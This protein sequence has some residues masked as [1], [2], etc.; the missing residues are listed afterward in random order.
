MSLL[1]LSTPRS[2]WREGFLSQGSVPLNLAEPKE[3]AVSPTLTSYLLSLHPPPQEN[4]EVFRFHLISV[5]AG[6][7]SLFFHESAAAWPQTVMPMVSLSPPAGGSCDLQVNGTVHLRL[8]KCKA[9]MS[10]SHLPGIVQL[11]YRS[12]V[13][14]SFLFSNMRT[15]SQTSRTITL[16]RGRTAW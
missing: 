5:C 2:C 11:V 6:F 9:G 13:L 16:T 10:F 1:L 4:H 8:L 7:P 14:V 3:E 12:V 15:G